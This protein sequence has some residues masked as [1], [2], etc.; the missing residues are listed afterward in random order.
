MARDLYRSREDI[1]AIISHQKSASE[2]SLLAQFI[3]NNNEKD[4]LLP[5]IMSIYKILI[6]QVIDIYWFFLFNYHKPFVRTH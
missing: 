3:V 5:Q 1:E 6:A 4:L 2:T